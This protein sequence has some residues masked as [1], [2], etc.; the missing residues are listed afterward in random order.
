MDNDNQKNQSDNSADIAEFKE[1][2]GS[3]VK[4]AG[5]MIGAASKVASRKGEALK[6]K[7]SDEE[8]QQKVK[9]NVTA[10]VK[11]TT[12]TASKTASIFAESAKETIEKVS[13][14]IEKEEEKEDSELLDG[15]FP[16]S[17]RNEKT[18]IAPADYSSDKKKEDDKKRKKSLDKWVIVVLLCFLGLAGIGLL[19]SKDSEKEGKILAVPAVEKTTIDEAVTT[20]NNAGFNDDQIVFYDSDNPEKEIEEPDKECTVVTQKPKEG[21]EIGET[22]A[23]SLYVDDNM[24]SKKELGSFVGKKCDKADPAIKKLGITPVYIASNTED[25]MTEPIQNDTVVAKD[26]KITKLIDYNKETAT[27]KF[28]VQSKYMEKEEKKNKRAEAKMS[29]GDAMNAVLCYGQEY[30]TTF[31]I[32]HADTYAKLQGGKWY[33]VGK[34]TIKNKKRK[35]T[36]RDFYAWV[37]GT[38]DNPVIEEFETR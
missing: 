18:S 15:A 31:R 3:F 11:A 7:L 20:I 37:S 34:Y 28:L 33:V 29:E 8:F 25:D 24:P 19:Q 4:A 32:K 10:T 38:R 36:T 2:A 27:A 9:S 14:A 13:E 17:K 35:K 30:D 6:E 16:S 5:K 23:I 22:D 21:E 12:E 1:A 26:F